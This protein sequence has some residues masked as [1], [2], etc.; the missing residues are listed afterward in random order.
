M[1]PNPSSPEADPA[2]LRH[3]GQWVTATGVIAFMGMTM[4]TLLGAAA[5]YLALPGF[6]W[7]FEITAILFIWTSF[8][9]AVLAEIKR[10]NVAMTVLVDRLSGR[11]AR[12]VGLAGAFAT[13]YFAGHLLVSGLA[14]ASRNGL[15]PTPL[16]RWPRLVM[17]LP[18]I[19]FAAGIGVTVLV[20]IVQDWRGAARR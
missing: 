4:T 14:F 7:T 2:V 5:R 1:Q 17:I 16:L 10:E 9:G 13:L 6:E 8:F 15:S 19:L 12:L 11:A 18:L 20:R 3:L